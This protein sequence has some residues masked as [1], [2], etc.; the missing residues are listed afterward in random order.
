MAEEWPNRGPE[1]LG[2]SLSICI[3]SVIILVWRIA[4][5]IESKRKLMVCDY[6]LIVAAVGS[7]LIFDLVLRN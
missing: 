4:Y 5:G 6:L 2:S 1:I 3:L 7:S